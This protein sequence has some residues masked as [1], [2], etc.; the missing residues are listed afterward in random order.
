LSKSFRLWVALG[1]LALLAILGRNA[2]FLVFQLALTNP[3]YSHI[4]LVIPVVLVFL[5]LEQGRE[6]FEGPTSPGLGVGFVMAGI[7]VWLVSRRVP[8]ADGLDLTLRVSALVLAAWAVAYL[9]YGWGFVR[10]A[11]FP[12]AFLCLLIPLPTSA[13]TKLTLVLQSGSTTAAY[14]LFKI[15]G[16]PVTRDGF[17]LSLRSVDIEVAKECSGIRSTV[18]LLVTAL[19]LGQWYL[20]APWR[21]TLVVLA[22]FPVGILRNGLRIFVLSILGTYVDEGWLEGNLHHRGGIAFFM[23]GLAMIVLLLW[24]L[25]R[26]E[27]KGPRVARGGPPPESF[28]RVEA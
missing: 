2:L 16:V 17:V 9:V 25:G 14:L 13:V 3:E 10:A 26:S 8:T 24:L 22:V 11:L 6:A 1:L 5:Y 12:I 7:V 20:R 4:L 23:A 18:M 21:R 15:F 27:R 19:V 28:G